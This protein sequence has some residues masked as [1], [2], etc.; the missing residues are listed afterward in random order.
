VASHIKV[1]KLVSYRPNY[2][3]VN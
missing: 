2:F 3:V 1:V